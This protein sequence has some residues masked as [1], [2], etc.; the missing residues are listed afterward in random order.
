MKKLCL[1]ISQQQNL[2]EEDVLIDFFIF[3]GFC[4]GHA[5]GIVGHALAGEI[6]HA[7]VIL[8]V[9]VP[10]ASEHAAAI[11]FATLCAGS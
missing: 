9:F 8:G 11:L 6:A 4:G 10:R 5:Y 1:R 2:S 7:S 3:F